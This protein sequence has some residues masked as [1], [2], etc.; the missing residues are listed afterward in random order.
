MEQSE[1]IGHK[2]AQHDVSCEIE[3]TGP[4]GT[5]VFAIGHFQGG[6]CHPN[7]WDRNVLFLVELEIKQQ[8]QG[9]DGG[10]ITKAQENG[11]AQHFSM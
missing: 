5:P 11:P 7:I 2:K 6:S 10:F 1:S 3:V 4:K 8:K 9:N